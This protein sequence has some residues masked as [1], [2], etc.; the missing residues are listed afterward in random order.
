MNTDLLTYSGRFD[1]GAWC[2]TIDLARE[3]FNAGLWDGNTLLR[4]RDPYAL[5]NRVKGVEHLPVTALRPD[6]DYELGEAG[7]TQ[8][9]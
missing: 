8:N 5:H 3:M 4:I 6:V 1:A 9:L 7:H 2:R